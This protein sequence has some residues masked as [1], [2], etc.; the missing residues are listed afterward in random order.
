[1]VSKKCFL[2]NAPY[3]ANNSVVFAPRQENMGAYMADIGSRLC[4]ERK[5]LGLSQQNLADSVGVDRRAIGRYEKGENVPGGAIL[6]SFAKLGA[7]VH[8]IL[9][10]EREAKSD[11]DVTF[12]DKEA[13]KA[14]LEVV[15]EFDS[16]WM[17]M[18]IRRE[19]ALPLFVAQY[20]AGD[21]GIR[22]VP[23][24]DTINENELFSWLKIKLSPELINDSKSASA[25]RFD[26]DEFAQVPMYDVAASAGHGALVEDEAVEGML[27]FRN[28]WIRNELR[29]N[30]SELYLVTVN[31][32][33]MYPTLS[34]NDIILV[35]DT[36]HTG[37]VPCDGIYLLRLDGSLLVKRLQ[38][39]PS[40]RVKII[41]DNP[42]YEA[43]EVA[44]DDLT[45]ADFCVL[46]RVVWSGRKM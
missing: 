31:G 6:A 46:G 42:S 12:D 45:D 44:A 8:Y 25:R 17:D 38:R 14:K 33:S 20:N 1:M 15:S 30:P 28:D 24:V 19:A 43:Y 34:P 26:K 35:H 4:E 29:V 21:K 9:T 16:F 32:D 11:S 37:S 10:G 27:V 13:L 41:S 39:R 22:K 5:R 36:S 18:E 40:N 23:G 2:N 3:L 7:N